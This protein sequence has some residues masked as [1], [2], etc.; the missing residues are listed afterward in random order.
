MTDQPLWTTVGV[1]RCVLERTMSMKSLAPGTTL[2][3]L[4]LYK[5]IM[6]RVRAPCSSLAL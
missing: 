2:M 3:V 6:R 1:P 4:K 5:T